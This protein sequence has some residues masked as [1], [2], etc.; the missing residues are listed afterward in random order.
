MQTAK[1]ILISSMISISLVL[2]ILYSFRYQV[3]TLV[4]VIPQSVGEEPQLSHVATNTESIP[5]IIN[6]VDGAVV[7]VVATKDVPVYERYLEEY[8]PFGDWFGGFSIPRIRENGTEEREVGGG[9]GFIVSGDGLIVTNRHVVADEDAAYSVVLA[10]G[11][12]HEVTV[13]AKDATLDVAVLEFAKKPETPLP[14]LTFGDSTKVQRGETVIVIGNALAEFDNSVSV[15]IISGIG[16][17]ISASDGRG[18]TEQ[19]SDVFQTDA[20]INPGNSGGP[21]LN[22][23]GEVIGV[24]VAASLGAENIGFAI[25]AQVVKQIVDSVVTYG[26]IKRPFLGVRYTMITARLAE[27]NNLPVSYGALVARGQTMEDLAVMPGSPADKAGLRENDIITTIDGVTLKDTDLATILRT[28]AV[29]ATVT[30][31]ILRQG[32]EETILVTLTEAPQE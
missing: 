24:N 7:S 25:P 28:K 29:D 14:Y 16:R 10:D 19:L 21:L 22:L 32:K 3:A 15:G 20:A 1:Q 30:L 12:I 8:N 18:M 2:L 27:K 9:T 11:T 23:R 4:G 26:Q 13:K 5:E 31:T 6:R 17:S